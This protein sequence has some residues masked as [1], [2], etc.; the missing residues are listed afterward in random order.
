MSYFKKTGN[1]LK[2]TGSGLVGLYEQEQRKQEKKKKEEPAKLRR[3]LKVLKLKGKVARE[4]KK[5]KGSS[6][7]WDLPTFLD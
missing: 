4:K 1:I 5:M 7:G 6:F 3:E 2:K